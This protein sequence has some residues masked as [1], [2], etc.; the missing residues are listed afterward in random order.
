MFVED[1]VSRYFCQQ[2][3]FVYYYLMNKLGII[4]SKE[5]Q[6]KYLSCS[7]IFYHLGVVCQSVLVSFENVAEILDGIYLD[8]C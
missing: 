4:D 8:M 1:G 6:K 3:I 5:K 2:V 7:M